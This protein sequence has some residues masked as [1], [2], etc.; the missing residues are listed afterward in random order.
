MRTL[1]AAD[2]PTPLEGP[3]AAAPRAAA[4]H[5]RLAA[6]APV[7]P[8]AALFALWAVLTQLDGGYFATT[9]YP[10][11]LVVC[12]LLA[13]VTI[14]GRL[15][16]PPGPALRV[17]LGCLAALTA[18]SFASMLWAGWPA[19]AW[20]T[21]NQLLVLVLG[22]WIVALTPWTRRSAAIVLGL[23]ALAT[24]GECAA[25]LVRALRASDLSPWFVVGRWDEPTG[26]PNGAAAVAVL[27]AWPALVLSARRET[28]A[29]AQVLLLPVAVFLLLFSLIAQSR[30]AILALIVV[31]PV[32][33]AISSHRLRLLA[34]MA[35]AG[36]AVALSM[37]R[38]FAVYTAAITG[39]PVIPALHAAGEAIGLAVALAAVAA[40]ALALF[41]RRFLPG[42]RVVRAASRATAAAFALAALV[43]LVL[44]AA[45]A[46][47][48]ADGIGSRWQTMEAGVQK[49][50]PTG[51]RFGAD[52]SDERVD[53]WRVS[54]DLFRD[55]PL[56]G[57][58][59]GNFEQHYAAERR[60][61]S[62]SRYPHDIWLRFLGEN[63]A[64]GL[65]LF[66][67]FLLAALGAPL[68]A[69]R[70]MDRSTRGVVA[71]TT[72]MA[73]GFLVQASV[74]W[75]DRM[76][77]IAGLALAAPLM[78]L[79]LA[80]RATTPTPAHAPRPLLPRAATLAGGLA[81]LLAALATLVPPYLAERYEQRAL[82]R[83]PLDP[84]GAFADFDRAARAN[85]LSGEP[86]MTKGTTALR[87][88]R[89]ALARQAFRAS[90]AVEPNWYPH[91]ELALMAAH[92]G[93]FG[94]ARRELDRAAA[95]NRSDQFI[96]E[97]RAAIVKRERVDPVAFNAKVLELTIYRRTLLK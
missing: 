88:G 16:P 45:H 55:A 95:L 68:L 10:A 85:P 79:R 83:A 97:A 91:F 15:A 73:L 52:I 17:A 64:V 96:A 21:S 47:Q 40:G 22:A 58:G 87:L 93:R 7:L 61:I 35:V 60:L 78:G 66:L 50:S 77:A 13:T 28:P 90:L 4:V 8:A 59:S 80:G 38:I 18:W 31:A 37:D 5:A 41:E 25:E 33:L 32:L 44:A 82:A 11:G 14:A 54:L 84:R 48:I 36:T 56:G 62:P 53:Y 1:P 30:G 23:W 42:P 72:A 2:P 51:P 92:D 63:G 76:P 19:S 34:R 20:E 43:A 67:G 26:Y 27:A 86:L 69:W 81:L 89:P 46:G 71:A 70:R 65:A 75:L 9:W 12:G 24:A 6:A 3:A 49:D 74:D 39:R 57:V 29:P 94:L